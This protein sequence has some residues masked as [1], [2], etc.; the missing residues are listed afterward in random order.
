MPADARRGRARR[1]HRRCV[2]DRA[3][4]RAC[5]SR[6]SELVVSYAL[7]FDI[8]AQHSGI[9]HVE[10]PGAT[11]T[12]VIHGARPV[13]I[14]IADPTALTAV[15]G[16]GARALP[17]LALLAL[18]T[19]LLGA[20][21]AGRGRPREL[22]DVAIAF[23]CAEAVTCVLTTAGDL[24]LPWAWV[25]P[26]VIGVVAVTGVLAIVGR[27]GGGA[28]ALE[29]GLVSGF[30][31]AHAFDTAAL[32]SRAAVTVIEFTVGVVLVQALVVVATVVAV[33]LWRRRLRTR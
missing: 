16:A 29:L 24:V 4:D 14:A 6:P 17:V 9:V 15:A 23:A 13:S 32:P 2:L 7:L 10:S 30:A 27:G 3:G 25:W 20:W 28:L 22:V 21:R 26:G 33:A 19:V 5:P 11:K 8:D 31:L 1:S 18:V 12:V